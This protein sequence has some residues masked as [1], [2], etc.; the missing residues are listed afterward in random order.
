MSKFP[1]PL[2]CE[3]VSDDIW[4]LHEPFRFIH[5][6]LGVLEE[7]I[8]VPAGYETDF[9]SVPGIFWSLVP[10]DGQYDG[11]AVIHDFLYGMKGKDVEPPRTRH[12]CDDIFLDGMAV[13]NVPKWKR[14]IM[15]FAVRIGG[16]LPWGG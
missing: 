7:T 9:A 16:W 13:L 15:W 12:E 10:K 2:I 4:K 1:D 14:D 11:A 8:V 3:H 5:N 6:R